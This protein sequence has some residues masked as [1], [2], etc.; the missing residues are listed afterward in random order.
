MIN[1]SWYLL[2]PYP[3]SGLYVFWTYTHQ[4]NLATLDGEIVDPEITVKLEVW[5]LLKVHEAQT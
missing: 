2:C 5:D 4:K 1:K 3:W